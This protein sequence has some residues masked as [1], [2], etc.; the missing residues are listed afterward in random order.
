[1][2]EVTTPEIKSLINA[3]RV[4]T[5]AETGLALGLVVFGAIIPVLMV[6]W[7]GRPEKFAEFVT[8]VFIGMYVFAVITTFAIILLWGLGRLDLPSKFMHWLG[9]A[10]IGEIAGMLF[11]VVQRLFRG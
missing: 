2:K 1:M 8:L 5:G 11:Y 4:V 6:L 3:A 9:A 7:W 10:T